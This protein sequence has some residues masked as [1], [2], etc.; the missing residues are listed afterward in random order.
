[1][2]FMRWYSAAYVLV[3][4]AVEAICWGLLLYAYAKATATNVALS[5]SSLP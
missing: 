2:E 5:H 1:M 3:S 4:G